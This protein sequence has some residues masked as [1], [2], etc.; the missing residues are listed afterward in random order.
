MGTDQITDRFVA[1]LFESSPAPIVAV[2]T[3]ERVTAWNPAATRLF[4]WPSEEVLGRRYPLVPEE[5]EQQ[6]RSTVD[7]VLEGSLIPEYTA[8]RRRKDG[9]LVDVTIALAPIRDTTDE[10]VG[11]LS[12]YNDIFQ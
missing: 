12:I 4:G 2:D 10:V 9:A 7:Q 1:S 6:Y 3:E 11:I 8:R 5:G